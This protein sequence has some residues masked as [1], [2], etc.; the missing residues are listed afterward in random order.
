MIWAKKALL[1]QIDELNA[2]PARPSIFGNIKRSLFLYPFSMT[3]AIVCIG[4]CIGAFICQS[5][6]N[7]ERV[8][9]A[10]IGPFLVLFMGALLI[11]RAYYLSWTS[12]YTELH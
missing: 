9:W 2:E 8:L 1:E 4:G 3:L 10:Y 5:W 11:A 12:K 6:Y 7:E